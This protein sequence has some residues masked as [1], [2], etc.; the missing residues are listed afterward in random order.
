MDD[1]AP[2]YVLGLVIREWEGSSVSRAL[3]FKILEML[4]AAPKRNADG[5][6]LTHLFDSTHTTT[7]D[8]PATYTQPEP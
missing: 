2:D 3:G 1:E 7:N 5:L 4:R 8:P 6:D